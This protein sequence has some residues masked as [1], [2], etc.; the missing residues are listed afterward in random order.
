MSNTKLQEDFLDVQLT[1]KQL[2]IF[3]VRNSILQALKEV[4]PLFSGTILDIGCG[5]M[6]YKSLVL[7]PPSNAT[8]YIGLDFA[9]NQIYQNQPDI[10]WQDQKIPL[11]N[12]S[13]DC[14]MATEVF[15]HCSESEIVM[16][17][18]LRVLKP[19]GTLFFTVP[20][21]FPLH[22]VPHDEYRYTPFSLE[23]H[24]KNAGFDQIQLKSLGGWDA[25]LAQMLGLW[26]NYRLSIYPKKQALISLLIK[27]LIW[28]LTKIDQPSPLFP[29]GQ[30]ITGLSGIAIKPSL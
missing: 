15:E 28:W 8:H 7:T 20:F 10:Y 19:G 13:V 11:T 1:R 17:E 22:D 25:S 5:Y 12:N 18:A 9:E 2:G 30:M 4:L 14:A 6:P 21:L 27:P 3:V 24:L 23:R 26:V 29:E 16:A